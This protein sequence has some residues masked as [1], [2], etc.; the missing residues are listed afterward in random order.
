[1]PRGSRRPLSSPPHWAF[2]REKPKEQGGQRRDGWGAPSHQPVSGLSASQGKA[3]VGGLHPQER[4]K[5]ELGRKEGRR[6]RWRGI[7]PSIPP[8]HA[9]MSTGLG[10]RSPHF[11]ATEPPL[12]VA[13][14]ILLPIRKSSGTG[15]YFVAA[16][17]FQ[18]ARPPPFLRA[19]VC[20][21]YLNLSKK[22]KKPQKT[23]TR[24]VSLRCF[25][26][27]RNCL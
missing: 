20:S 17:G 15:K 13:F 25:V 16:S 9:G 1:M 12:A 11:W 24:T 10:L 7:H 5:I 6:E 21:C 18:T 4:L 19:Y 27:I 2:C 22:K 3:E 8:G 14:L 26:R 23:T